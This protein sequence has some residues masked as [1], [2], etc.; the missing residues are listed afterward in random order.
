MHSDPDNFY[1]IKHT[2]N[3][4]NQLLGRIDLY[5][6]TLT[7]GDIYK[8]LAI[9]VDKCNEDIDPACRPY[10]SNVYAALIF[11]NNRIDPYESN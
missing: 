9:R 11:R 3:I 2:P 10:K 5:D 7:N 1:T 4:D 6:P 8:R